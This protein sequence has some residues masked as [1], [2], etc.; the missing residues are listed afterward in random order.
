M[1]VYECMQA[2]LPP[3]S[4]GNKAEGIKGACN[5]VFR[6]GETDG[7]TDGRTEEGPEVTGIKC[8]GPIPPPRCGRRGNAVGWVRG[9]AGGAR[10]PAAI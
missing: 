1:C 3:S 4:E 10:G 7:R 9:A 2:C 8:V 5:D 6:E